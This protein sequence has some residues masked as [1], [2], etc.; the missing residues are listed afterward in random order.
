MQTWLVTI[1]AIFWVSL[2]IFLFNAQDFLKLFIFSEVTWIVLFVTSILFGINNDDVNLLTLSF[3]LLGFA[4]VEFVI[5]YLLIILFKKF[6]LELNFL[7]NDLKYQS[8]LVF[9]LK[10]LNARKFLWN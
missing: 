8:F 7:K 5:A 2:V 3:F 9:N 4:S 1:P 6:N 10:K